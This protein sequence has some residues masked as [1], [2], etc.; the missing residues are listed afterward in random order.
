MS[1]TDVQRSSYSR[2]AITLHWLIALLLIGNFLGGLLLDDLFNSPDA[3]TRRLGFTVVQLH[4]SIGLTV[5]TLTLLRLAVRLVSPPPPLPAHMTRIERLLSRVTHGTFYALMI[6]IPL[7]GWAMVSASPLG[8][9]T[10]W[11]GLFE[12]PH[13]PITPGKQGADAASEAHEILAFSAAALVVLHVAA[14]LKHHF[15]DR[16]DVLARM[17]PLIRKG[18][19]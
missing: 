3:G 16:D 7:S 9:P 13:L 15:W 17:L 2:I 12:W 10:M 1:Q 6:L 8:F 18:Q 5:L 14:A 19:G 11:F 4:K